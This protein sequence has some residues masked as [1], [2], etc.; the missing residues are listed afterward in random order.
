MGSVEYGVWEAFN[1]AVLLSS[2]KV[3]ALM[4][5]VLDVHGFN[6]A[7]HGMSIVRQLVTAFAMRRS[8]LYL[9]LIP[10]V[11]GGEGVRLSCLRALHTRAAVAQGMSIGEAGAALR[12]LQSISGMLATALF[13]FVYQRGSSLPWFLAAMFALLG[14]G[15]FM[16]LG[17]DEL[18][19]GI[20]DTVRPVSTPTAKA[21]STADPELESE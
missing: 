13:G 16:M 1:G 12:T 18:L 17:R 3:T 9:A 2:S 5:R 14:E 21:K 8:H 7:A 15:V 19:K 6:L 10:E 4:L 11:F 20:E